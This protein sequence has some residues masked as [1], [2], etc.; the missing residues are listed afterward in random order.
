MLRN[1]ITRISLRAI[2][3]ILQKCAL[4]NKLSRQY[5]LLFTTAC[6]SV[7][8]NYVIL[9]IEPSG[10]LWQPNPRVICNLRS[11]SYKLL[12][13]AVSW[14]YCQRAQRNL[15]T[16]PRNLQIAPRDFLIEKLR[17][18]IC[19]ICILRSAIYKLL[20]LR[21][22]SSY[23]QIELRSLQTAQH[24]LWIELAQFAI[25]AAQFTNYWS[26]QSRQFIDI[27]RNAI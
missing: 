26:C 17:C 21:V 1:H 7:G 3:T 15:Q 10:G 24:D 12:K 11:A 27:L 4:L 2:Y 20:K 16:A 5:A 18:A 19:T 14:I 25:Y 23:H 8:P 22:L 13:L 6:Q 9:I